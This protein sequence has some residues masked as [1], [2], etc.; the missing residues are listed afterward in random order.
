MAITLTNLGSAYGS[1]CDTARQRHL[2]ERALAIKEREYGPDHL[3]VAFTLANLADA[4]GALSE[5]SLAESVS[6]RALRI[7][8]AALGPRPNAVMA[9]L[10]L[11]VSLV[12]QAAGKHDAALETWRAAEAELTSA[13]G[14]QTAWA[15]VEVFATQAGEFWSAVSRP[16]VVQWLA[17]QKCEAGGQCA[18]AEPDVGYAL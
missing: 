9:D 1:L 15:K 18:Q 6:S 13:V 16:D 4:Y 2:L 8:R 7:A 11:S 12:R 3:E 14:E 10:L 5:E 17:T